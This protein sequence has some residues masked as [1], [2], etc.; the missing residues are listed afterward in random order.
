MTRTAGTSP[1]TVVLLVLLVSA[2]P[3]PVSAQA[4]SLPVTVRV[5]G[6]RFTGVTI[7]TPE[8]LR[9]VVRAAEGRGLTLAQLE[10]LAALITAKYRE[11]GHLLARAY[12]PAQDL[13]D[14]VV[15][16]AVS[17]GRIGQVQVTGARRYG[18]A[19]LGAHVRP[20]PAQPVF[21]AR[22]FERGLLLLNDLPGLQV[23]STLAPGGEP[24]TTDIVLDV[25][26]ERLVTAA[27]EVNNYGSRETGYERLDV[28]LG[29]NNPLGWNDVFGI[30]GLVSRE[31]DALWFARGTY[32]IAL[33]ASGARLS[34]AYTHVNSEAGVQGV[35]GPINVTGSGDIGSLALV[36]PIVRQRAWSL[37]AYG[38]FDVSN[39]ENE[40]AA[41]D[42]EI[43]RQDRLRVLSAGG[44]LN[45]VDAWRGV[46]ALAVT[47]H[48][49]L[50]NFLGGLEADEDPDAS[51]PGGGGTFTKLVG[52]VSRL[53]QVWGPVSLY[54]RAAGQWASTDLVAAEQFFVGGIG[55]VRGYALAQFAGDHGYS[56]TG[57]VR[58]A[59]PGFSD[60]PALLGK[61]WGEVLQLHAFVDTGWAELRQP[62]PGERKSQQLTGVGAGLSLSVADNFLLNVEY[63]RPVG[64]RSS[65]GRDNVVYF[66]AVKLF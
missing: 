58:L 56:L 57:E 2:L 43:T 9:A 23:K 29:L 10:T 13:V 61:T 46:S 17:E 40:S 6:F 55:T 51:R 36:H 45:V 50:G 54:V 37:F 64:P 42:E 11:R 1:V 34:L 38:G 53:Q 24:G 65:D 4:P 20:D 28:S 33:G 5:T 52:Q 7:F 3:A 26:R 44:A 19:F 31:G 16:I 32:G 30:R 8:E 22:R 63:A 47:L 48:Q 25:A 14:G 49:G 41:E 18:P 35:I 60:V 62:L 27:L 66:R 21:D 15:E 12:V 39:L 59:A